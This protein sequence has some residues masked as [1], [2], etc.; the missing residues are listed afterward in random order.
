MTVGIYVATVAL[1]WMLATELFALT[2]QQLLATGVVAFQPKLVAMG[3][4]VNPDALPLFALRDRFPMDGSPNP[5][6]RCD[7]SADA[8]DVLVRRRQEC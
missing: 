1:M 3:A 2:W 7:I 5:S 4:V 6:A 8:A